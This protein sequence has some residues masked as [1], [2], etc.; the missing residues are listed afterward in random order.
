MV[1]VKL[2]SSGPA[3][4]LVILDVV[5]GTIVRDIPDVLAESY[6]NPPL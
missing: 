6:D 2:V 3:R 1:V 5:D 4:N